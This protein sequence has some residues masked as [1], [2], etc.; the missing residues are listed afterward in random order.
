MGH[1]I[2]VSKKA[3]NVTSASC[4][5]TNVP[6]GYKNIHLDGGC[7][8]PPCRLELHST[9]PEAVA[10][11]TELWGRAKR[12][13]PCLCLGEAYQRALNCKGI[14]QTFVIQGSLL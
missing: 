14:Y 8:A 3:M 11:S 5:K 2:I 12:I 1:L 9:A 4:T 13:L 10:L 6:S 7:L